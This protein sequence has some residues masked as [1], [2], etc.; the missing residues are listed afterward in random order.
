MIFINT[1]LGTLGV[2][3][4]LLFVGIIAAGLNILLKK[5]PKE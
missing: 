1:F 2:I 5:K 3:S 4:G